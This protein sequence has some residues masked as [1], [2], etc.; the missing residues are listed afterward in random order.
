MWNLRRRPRSAAAFF[1]GLLLLGC[2]MGDEPVATSTPQSPDCSRETVVVLVQSFFETWNSGQVGALRAL[3][4]PGFLIDD[5]IDGRR[6]RINS[7]ETLATYLAQRGA[8]GDR[9][10]DLRADVPANP[11]PTSA[12]ATIAFRRLAGGT[13]YKG[14]A[15]IVCVANRISTVVMTSE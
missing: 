2:N 6:S 8:R 5:G 15:K 9:F 1:A 7:D 14:N 3:L 12:N 4:G 13:T 11:S 10:E